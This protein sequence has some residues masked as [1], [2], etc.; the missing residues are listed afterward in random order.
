MKRNDVLSLILVGFLSVGFVSCGSDNEGKP[1]VAPAPSVT[2]E[3]PFSTSNSV[4]SCQTASSIENFRD[5]VSAG[6]FMAE[7]STYETYYYVEQEPE[8]DKGKFLGFIPYNTFK[9]ETLGDF[10]RMGR[11]DSDEISHEAGNNKANVRDYLMNILDNRKDVRGGGSYVEVLTH[12][13]MIYGIDLCKPLAANPVY[14]ADSNTGRRYFYTG[15]NSSNSNPNF[16][17][18]PY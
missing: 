14:E 4:T 8:I 17:F 16:G 12:S 7:R 5:K 15:T 11:K 6:K 13:G 2:S 10:T 18:R 3:N 9:W 1:G